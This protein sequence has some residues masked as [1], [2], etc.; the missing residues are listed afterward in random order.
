M[1]GFDKPGFRE[2]SNQDWKANNFFFVNQKIVEMVD[3]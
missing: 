1:I 3:L 2:N